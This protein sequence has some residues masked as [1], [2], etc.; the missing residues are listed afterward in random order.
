M[1]ERNID[2]YYL[3]QEYKNQ[4]ELEYTINFTCSNKYN[5]NK[6]IRIYLEYG[7]IHDKLNE[8]RLENKFFDKEIFITDLSSIIK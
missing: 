3:V 7:D 2:K 1:K 4:S 8:K 5:I 6:N